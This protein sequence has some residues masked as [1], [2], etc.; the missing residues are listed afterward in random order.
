MAER[1]IT[2][3][4][5]TDQKR[6]SYTDKGGATKPSFTQPKSNSNIEVDIETGVTIFQEPVV[7]DPGSDLTANT[8]ST[9]AT[10]TVLTNTYNVIGTCANAGDACTLS[11][12]F[13][14][15]TMVIVVNRGIAAMDLFP[16]VGGSIAGFPAN[17]PISIPANGGAIGL[18][19]YNNDGDFWPVSNPVLTSSGSEVLPS[20][21]F[22]KYQD[23]GMYWV[24]AD[25][26]GFSTAGAL[27]A[28]ITNG[29]INLEDSK[30]LTLGTGDDI[31][32]QWNGTTVTSGPSS[33]LWTGAPSRLDPD[34]YKF[35]EIFDDFIT[36]VDTG[37]HWL[38]SDDGGTGTNAYTDIRGGSLSI[39][40]AAADNDYHA[41]YSS[42]QAFNCADT[43]ELWFEA[44]F[45]LSEANTN[46]SA[47]WFGL[48]DTLTTG[49]F[50]ADVL[51]PLASYDGIL[52]WKDEATMTIQAETSNA[53]TQDTESSVGTFV[54]NTWTRVG[55]HVSAAA[56]T[57][58]VTA[59]V[60]LSDLGVMTAHGTT[61]NLTRAGL[62]EMHAIM[63]VKAGPTAGAE[64]L[65]VDYIK[66]VQIR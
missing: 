9:Q 30:S 34:P 46:E 18:F 51:G 24:A 8:G 62:E 39:V 17:N 54:T 50:Q 53:G 15:G 29:G 10:G 22:L 21:S 40:T 23:M 13:K 41:M 28:S 2:N 11:S 4:V 20:Y 59:Y 43:K 48:T 42:A 1:N 14:K 7:F 65:E 47:W 3:K 57:A 27:Q 16:E 56:T 35:I 25:E 52:M 6:G 37:T 61:M 44:R 55:F 12:S 26:L 38:S 45:R 58:V 33:G 66:V 60:D 19:A 49:G 64:T 36:G 5:F 32:V 31:L 63:G